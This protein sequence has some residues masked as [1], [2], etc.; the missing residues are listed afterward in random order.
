[1]RLTFSSAFWNGFVVCACLESLRQDM[2]GKERYIKSVDLNWVDSRITVPIAIVGLTV[3]LIGY[4]IHR[5]A[6]P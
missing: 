4:I 1:M 6:T 3:C 2:I 5:K